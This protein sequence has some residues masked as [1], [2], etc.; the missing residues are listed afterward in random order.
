MLTV[1]LWAC[2]EVAI[3][4]GIIHFIDSRQRDRL[5]YKRKFMC[6]NCLAVN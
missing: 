4:S 6:V 5:L 1:L 3:V 2:V